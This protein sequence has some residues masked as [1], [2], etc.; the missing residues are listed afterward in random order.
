MLL[1]ISKS[2][3]LSKIPIICCLLTSA[4]SSSL[5]FW[6]AFFRPRFFFGSNKTSWTIKAIALWA[7]TTSS[8]KKNDDHPYKLSC[9]AHLIMYL[10]VL[11]N[12]SSFYRL[13]STSYSLCRHWCMKI[14]CLQRQHGSLFLLFLLTLIDDSYA[15]S[16][17]LN[18]YLR[19]GKFYVNFIG[20]K[21]LFSLTELTN[22]F[23]KKIYF[24]S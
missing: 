3:N 1:C 15:L 20:I 7:E 14:Q 4:A 18:I 19:L 12:G 8:L 11:I 2:I 10:I 23:L 16:D 22:A 5:S 13:C 17:S 9:I 6:Y 21:I 24:R